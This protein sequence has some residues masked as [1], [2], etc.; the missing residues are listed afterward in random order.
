MHH[1][2]NLHV[3]E[4]SAGSGKTYTLVKYY[5]KILLQNNESA[6]SYFRNILAITFT[7]KA[8]E[9]MKERII[10]ALAELKNNNKDSALLTE[11][12]DE[13]GA[14]KNEIRK[15]AQSAFRSILHNYSDFAV[16]TI[17]S[18]SFKIIRSLAH[19]FKLRQ[20]VEALINTDKIKKEAIV[21]LLDKVYTSEE[22]ELKRILL[23]LM[24]QRMMNMKNPDPRPELMK[25]MEFIENEDWIF[26]VDELMKKEK[27]HIKKALEISQSYVDDFI[28]RLKELHQ[29]FLP[30]LKEFPVEYLY[31]KSRS[32]LLH[33]EDFDINKIIKKSDELKGDS[34][35]NPTSFFNKEYVKH[36]LKHAG[37][38]LL[39]HFKKMVDFVNEQR[40][41]YQFHKTILETK[42]LYLLYKNIT[43]EFNYVKK[44]YNVIPVS[45]FNV[46]ISEHLKTLPVPYIYEKFGERYKHFLIDEFQDTSKLQWMNL[47]HLV[48]NSL[49]EGH[50]CMLVGDL[51]QSIYRWR[52]A[53]PELMLKLPLIPKNFQEY[54]KNKVF[55]YSYVK[56]KLPVN[57]RSRKNIVEFN[58]LFFSHIA[59]TSKN[60][61]IQEI[62][63]DVRQQYLKE[64]DGGYIKIELSEDRKKFDERGIEFTYQAIKDLTDAG[65]RFNEICI[66]VRK[67]MEIEQIL[68]EF[69]VRYSNQIKF[70]RPEPINIQTIPFIRSFINFVE[71]YLKDDDYYFML[72]M[73]DWVEMNLI[74]ISDFRNLMCLSVI[75]RKKFAFEN[76]FNYGNKSIKNST[77]K[78]L[79]DYYIHFFPDNR[80][81]EIFRF[82]NILRE[83]FLDFDLKYKNASIF[84]FLKKWNS[85]YSSKAVLM[86]AEEDSVQIMTIHKSKGLQFKAVI[87]PF[88]IKKRDDYAKKYEWFLSEKFVENYP[89]KYVLLPQDADSDDKGHKE[90]KDWNELEELNVL[91]VAMTRA[92]DALF[93]HS[94]EKDT[95]GK[96]IMSLMNL[97]PKDS[98]SNIGILVHYESEKKVQNEYPLQI[99]KILK[100]NHVRDFSWNAVPW[101]FKQNFSH[102]RRTGEILHAAVN[103]YLF[104]IFKNKNLPDARHWIQ[105]YNLDADYAGSMFE[106][107]KN[108]QWLIPLL[109]ESNTAWFEREFYDARDNKILRPDLVVRNAFKILIVDFKTGYAP[110]E[111]KSQIREYM[112]LFKNDKNVSVTGMIFYLSD[113]E[114]IILE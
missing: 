61:Y 72:W 59:G 79:L 24:E 112:N 83:I 69:N 77:L 63:K 71:F 92:E 86:P 18:F 45:E 102:A 12:A 84:D 8:T 108:N 22:G 70:S 101:V 47:N 35:E 65:Y 57:R 41:F 37:E 66:L 15:R 94:H 4:S 50:L 14:D 5:L 56:F 1:S 2:Q 96:S 99:A 64:K 68:E 75:E 95:M 21:H 90:S 74:S 25:L 7:N 44:K 28:K 67:N 76:Y 49:S 3:Y 26:F 109:L 13:I 36:N 48:E 10:S 55:D 20:H 62:Y 87:L 34:I 27:E 11:L 98:V 82:E 51:K 91:Y 103:D 93:I 17:D 111:Q 19:E 100:S 80:S 113:S 29:S 31:G 52:N 30:H 46:K 54:G 85:D 53:D 78:D 110:D 60:K 33:F 107:I 58:N 97:K 105:K 16:Q 88:F 43:D 38:K 81:M 23:D 114:N 73:S 89:L 42:N 104:F 106:K 32:V 6:C 39:K 9:E 40:S